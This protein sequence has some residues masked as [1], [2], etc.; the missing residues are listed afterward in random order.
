[1]LGDKVDPFMD[2]ISVSITLKYQLLA[3]GSKG[4]GSY[5]KDECISLDN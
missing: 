2:G 3:L 5:H 1:V 4:H